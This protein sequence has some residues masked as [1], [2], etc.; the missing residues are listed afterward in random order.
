MMGKAVNA[1]L[2]KLCIVTPCLR[3]MPRQTIQPL[4]SS[5]LFVRT[6]YRISP[7][8]K[9]GMN[10]TGSTLMGAGSVIAGLSDFKC[11]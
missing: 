2:V 4:P 9:K 3:V 1:K 10:T 7:P 11:F 5:P 6:R 8:V